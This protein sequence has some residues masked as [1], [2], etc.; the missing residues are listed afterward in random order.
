[1]KHFTLTDYLNLINY[2]VQEGNKFLWNCYGPNA[3]VY[4]YAGSETAFDFSIIF[5]TVDRL[6]YQI[7][8]STDDD[9]YRWTNP[10]FKDAYLAEEV[11]TSNRLGFEPLDFQDYTDK[12]DEFMELI[13]E[14]I[15]G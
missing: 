15:N 11:E 10:E 14:V 3:Y 5:D 2:Q 4:S 13:K 1:M 6:I 8:L 12:P 9:V 7:E